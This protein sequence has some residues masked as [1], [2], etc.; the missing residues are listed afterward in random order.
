MDVKKKRKEKKAGRSRDQQPHSGRRD[1]TPSDTTWLRLRTIPE[2]SKVCL[3]L[4]SSPLQAWFPHL[5]N[6]DVQVCC[7][8]CHTMET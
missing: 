2:C 8:L 7:E 1:P 6:R 5:E 3:S 4:V